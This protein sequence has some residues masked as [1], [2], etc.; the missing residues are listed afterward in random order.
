MSLAEIQYYRENAEALAAR[1]EDLSDEIDD[2]DDVI[3]NLQAKLKKRNAEI[4][5]LKTALKEAISEMR[6]LKKKVR[7]ATDQV[8]SGYYI[9]NQV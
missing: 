4:E 3:G 1:I 9:L 8:F 7:G 2:C 6:D 5:T